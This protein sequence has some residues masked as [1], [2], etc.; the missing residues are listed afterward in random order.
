MLTVQ[1]PLSSDSLAEEAENFIGLISLLSPDPQ[2]LI[3]PATATV[4]IT[5]VV[6]KY[7]WMHSMCKNYRGVAKEKQ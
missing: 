6:S 7:G 3:D 1:V 5:D 2:V 4:D